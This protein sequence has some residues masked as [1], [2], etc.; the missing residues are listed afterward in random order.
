MEDI[1]KMQR[2][3]RLPG[4]GG[5]KLEGGEKKKKGRMFLTREGNECVWAQEGICL[6]Q[7]RV[8]HLQPSHKDLTGGTDGRYLDCVP[9]NHVQIL[10]SAST[11]S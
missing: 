8:S 10:Q 7:V 4:A 11:L 2:G 9:S 3:K 5:W 6:G 1:K